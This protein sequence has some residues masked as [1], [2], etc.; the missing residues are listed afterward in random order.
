MRYTAVAAALGLAA[1]GSPE[2]PLSS[3]SVVVLHHRLSSQ[4]GLPAGS[5]SGTWALVG[6]CLAVRSSVATATVLLP[7]GW[8]FGGSGVVTNDG[9][10][11]GMLGQSVRL[12][13][14]EV[15]SSSE[16]ERLAAE[17]VPPD[18]VAPAVWLVGELLGP[19]TTPPV[20]PP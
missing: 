14:G 15:K 17:P 10:K 9:R 6:R 1:C 8:T 12:G 11:A 5:T 3:T 4:D 13:G 19:E 2:V 16:V 18:C 20:T 7:A